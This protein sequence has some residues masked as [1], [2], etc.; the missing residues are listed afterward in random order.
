M[1]FYYRRWQI[2]FGGTCRLARALHTGW[3]APAPHGGL[4]PPQPPYPEPGD[5]PGGS[6]PHRAQARGRAVLGAPRPLGGSALSKG[7]PSKC[8]KETF[9]RRYCSGDFMWLQ[10]QGGS[11]EG[12][13]TVFL[14][15]KRGNFITSLWFL[16]EVILR[17]I[18]QNSICLEKP[19]SAEHL[20]GRGALIPPNDLSSH[21]EQRYH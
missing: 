8:D 21:G 15:L 13:E 20:K 5:P 19:L 16:K 11:F 1:C 17:N 2:V 4:G 14:L 9:S 3:R 6:Q 18:L 7:N 12:L 10:T